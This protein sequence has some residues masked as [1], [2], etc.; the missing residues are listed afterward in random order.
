MGNQAC[1][2]AEL[3]PTKH[4][5]ITG[6]AGPLTAKK[7]RRNGTRIIP[8][9][10]QNLLNIKDLFSSTILLDTVCPRSY[11]AARKF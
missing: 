6:N 8:R 5:K 10:A 9:L 11:Y 3:R 4:P 2:K 1:G 7:M